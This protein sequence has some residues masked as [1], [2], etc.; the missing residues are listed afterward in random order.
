MPFVIL[1][2]I[3]MAQ[4][5]F[6]N[7]KLA[8]QPTKAGDGTT[9]D[10]EKYSHRLIYKE[11]LLE[12]AVDFLNVP[13]FFYNKLCVSNVRVLLPEQFKTGIEADEKKH[14][15]HYKYA[16]KLEQNG[17]SNNTMK[18]QLIGGMKSAK[19]FARIFEN[20]IS[21][22]YG[23]SSRAAF[24]RQV[25]NCGSVRRRNEWRVDEMNWNACDH[26]LLYRHKAE[27]PSDQT[28]SPPLGTEKYL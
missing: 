21:F 12:N 14:L 15:N 20:R 24:I 22:D 2:L 23:V 9:R 19:K 6:V 3:M 8:F 1:A 25:F 16:E 4:Y 18:H 27:F 26:D 13:E 7:P 5:H 11:T 10:Y 28:R 17:G